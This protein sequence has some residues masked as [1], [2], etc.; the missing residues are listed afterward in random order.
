MMLGMINPNN[1][2]VVTSGCF[3]DKWVKVTVRENRRVQL[4]G[5]YAGIYYILQPYKFFHEY[6]TVYFVEDSLFIINLTKKSKTQQEF[7]SPSPSLFLYNQGIPLNEYAQ[8]QFI[9]SPFILYFFNHA[10]S[11]MRPEL[12]KGVLRHTEKQ[13]DCT[14]WSRFLA[15]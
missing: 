14:F 8:L 3:R 2:V 6:F 12:R 1:M 10:Y 7:N 15:T 5:G 9:M 4:S 11:A 13:K